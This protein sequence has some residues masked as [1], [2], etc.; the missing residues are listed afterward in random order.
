MIYMI[1][2][3]I[4]WEVEINLSLESLC[5]WVSCTLSPYKAFWIVLWPVII[6]SFICMPSVR[7]ASQNRSWFGGWRGPIWACVHVR[8][9]VGTIQVHKGP[10]VSVIIRVLGVFHVGGIFVYMHTL[11]QAYSISQLLHFK[12]FTSESVHSKGT[13]KY[14]VY[15]SQNSHTVNLSR[16]LQNFSPR[17]NLP[18]GKRHF[19]SSNGSFP[20]SIKFHL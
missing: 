3:Y 4:T 9:S 7:R 18:S 19:F 15:L 1:Y 8:D 16:F 12:Y 10:Y 13:G 17:S 2:I 6:L 20:P 11:F 5:F 14:M